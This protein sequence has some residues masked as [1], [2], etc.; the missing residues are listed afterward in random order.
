MYRYIKKHENLDCHLTT[1][2][3]RS[4]NKVKFKKKGMRKYELYLKSPNVRGIKVWEM[5]PSNVQKAT[6][7]VKF[8]NFIKSICKIR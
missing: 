5:L 4:S 7:K 8:K 3:L 2:N 6:I 1:M